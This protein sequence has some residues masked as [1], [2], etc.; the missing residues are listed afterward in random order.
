MHQQAAFFQNFPGEDPP[1][2]PPPF[3]YGLTTLKLLP[4]VLLYCVLSLSLTHS[5]SFFLF[6]YSDTEFSDTAEHLVE[7]S[8]PEFCKGKGEG[9]YRVTL[10]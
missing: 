4:L 9:V 6:S 2:P 8:S 3:S 10:E 7:C 1:D 5:L